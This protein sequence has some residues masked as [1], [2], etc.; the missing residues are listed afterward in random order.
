MNEAVDGWEGKQIMV[1]SVLSN[2]LEPHLRS[3][4]PKD[5]V[6]FPQTR[7]RSREGH[8]KKSKT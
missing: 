4:V 6:L 7:A 8:Q 3:N 5:S 1:H 2:E